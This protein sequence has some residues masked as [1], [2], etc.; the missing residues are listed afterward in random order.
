M[1]KME[2][3]LRTKN[4]KWKLGFM[5]KV[6]IGISAVL[7]IGALIGAF[8]LNLQTRELSENWMVA[9]NIIADLDYLTSEFRLKQYHHIVSDTEEEYLAVE[10]EVKEVNEKISEQIESYRKTISSETDKKYFEEAYTAWS[11]Y[12]EATGTGLFEASR[13]GKIA[14]AKEIMT[15]EGYEAFSR[16]QTNFDELLNFNLEQAEK[17]SN[18]AQIA[19][20]VV[21]VLVLFFVALG[22]LIGSSVSKI[23]IRAITE[24]IEEVMNVTREMTEGNLHAS[25]TYEGEDELGVLADAMRTTQNT[26]AAYIREISDLLEEIAKGDLT[27]E[28]NKITDFKGDFGSIK[29]S[30]VHILEEF[31]VTLSQIQGNSVQVESGSNDIAGAASDLASGTTEQA[32]AVEELTATINTVNNMAEESAK[33]AEESYQEVLVSVENAETE[34]RQMQELQDEMARIKEISNEVEAIIGT[35]EEIASQTSLLSLNASIEAARAGEA[36]RG[37][38]VVADQIGKLA[39]DSAQAAV[40]TKDLINKTIEEID[41]GNKITEDAVEGF[42]HIIEELQK[43]ATISQQNSE[44]SM[45][46]A[47]AL[48]QVEEG[49]EQISEVTQAN[50]ASSEEC[51]AIS[52]ELAAR[53]TE[54]DALVKKFVLYHG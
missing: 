5:A 19:F 20:V 24:P 4:V 31:N 30:F 32:S 18:R 26:L 23:I 49:I 11:Q 14:E 54:L 13:A 42:E 41:K 51:S 22:V 15:G 6:M 21:V 45:T 34:K 12:V 43:F 40:N 8:E 1:A 9:N 44:I 53:A 25:L 38:A 33:R 3:M 16:F 2:T 50:A 7:G 28:F 48:G 52:E 10:A 29:E 37:F 35:I 46:Q 47:H 27:R 39:T 36:G 17:A